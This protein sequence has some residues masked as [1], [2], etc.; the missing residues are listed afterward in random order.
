MSSIFDI[1]KNE[2]DEIH[3]VNMIIKDSEE[4]DLSYD[5]IIDFEKNIHHLL[6]IKNILKNTD[7]ENM[8]NIS[9]NFRLKK[10]KQLNKEDLTIKI[11]KFL[12]YKRKK[13]IK[14]FKKNNKDLEQNDFC[15]KTMKIYINDFRNIPLNEKLLRIKKFNEIFYFL[16]QNI[17]FII[18]HDNF[19]NT[20][21]LKMNEISNHIN[22]NYKKE[23]EKFQKYKKSLEFYR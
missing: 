15:I 12:K 13:I 6:S 20:I 19:L 2:I 3:I 21:I 4:I 23:Y 14:D 16:S 18:I 9:K 22:E 11:N 8:L 17:F 1:L 10:Y 5:N 7:R